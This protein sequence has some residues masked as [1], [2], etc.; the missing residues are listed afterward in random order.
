MPFFFATSLLLDEFQPP[1]AVNVEGGVLEAFDLR[2][3][4]SAR[5]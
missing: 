4:D 2:R 3:V 5:E 1:R